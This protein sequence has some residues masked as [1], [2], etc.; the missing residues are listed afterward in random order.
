MKASH[1]DVTTKNSLR[2]LEGGDGTVT[3]KKITIPSDLRV[4]PQALS[5]NVG[6]PCE[7]PSLKSNGPQRA[8]PFRASAT[9]LKFRVSLTPLAKY[10]RTQTREFQLQ[11]L[12]IGPDCCQPSGCDTTIRF[13]FVNKKMLH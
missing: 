7:S 11:P 8:K 12:G 13:F 5:V 10:Q 3:A 2:S 4:H 9:T 1:A 6:N